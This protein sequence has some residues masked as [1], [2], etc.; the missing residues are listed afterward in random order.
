MTHPLHLLS[1]TVVRILNALDAKMYTLCRCLGVFL[2]FLT[3]ISIFPLMPRV[4]LS[5]TTHI[6][7]C[8]HVSLDAFPGVTLERP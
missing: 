5:H 6:L 2:V 8:T 7:K 3:K 1:L 4:V